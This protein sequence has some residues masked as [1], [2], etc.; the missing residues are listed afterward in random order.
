MDILGD[1]FEVD[2]EDC[3]H[4]DGYHEFGLGCEVCGLNPPDCHEEER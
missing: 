1:I 3:D 2:P 4:D